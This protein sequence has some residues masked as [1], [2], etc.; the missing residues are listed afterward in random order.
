MK[1]DDWHNAK[2]ESDPEYAAAYAAAALDPEFMAEINALNPPPV[3][4]SVPEET[5]NDALSEAL[6]WYWGTT[7]PV[8]LRAQWEEAG[9]REP[10][11]CHDCGLAYG[12]VG[13]IECVVP[14]DVWRQIGPTGDE[15]GIL[16]I[17]CIARRAKRHGLKDVPVM[18]CGTE[19]LR[20]ANQDEAFDRGYGVAERNLKELSARCASLQAGYSDV[21]ALLAE[22]TRRKAA[23]VL[24]LNWQV[25]ADMR[26]VERWLEQEVDALAA[27]NPATEEFSPCSSTGTATNCTP[28]MPSK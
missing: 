28:A 7:D 27:T 8:A 11:A 21:R 17:T 20:N 6:L 26:G 3:F 22:I 1:I 23:A 14:N 5:A 24:A 9:T 16:C 12:D 15:G 19:V 10:T 13:W 2:M 4:A 18:L 25:A